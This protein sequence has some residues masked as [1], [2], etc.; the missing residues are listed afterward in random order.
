[1]TSLASPKDF[2]ILREDAGLMIA[3]DG[4]EDS[5]MGVVFRE[6]QPYPYREGAYLIPFFA[7]FSSDLKAPDDPML[8]VQLINSSRKDP[9]E[10]TLMNLVVPLLRYFSFQACALGLLPEYNA[11]NILIDWNPVDNAIR[12]VHRD[13]TGTF[14]DFKQRRI[15]GLHCNMNRYHSTDYD[16]DQEDCFRRRSFAYDFKLG[17]YVFAELEN[18]LLTDFGI[19]SERLR[20]AIKSCFRDHVDV[21]IEEYFG[22]E[23]TWYGY[24]P[25][26]PHGTRPY[27]KYSN[28]K[29]RK[30]P[31][32]NK[33]SK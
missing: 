27:V 32:R 31:L 2:A 6:F 4:S 22:S 1:M 30:E 13:M 14:K 26:L 15:L 3:Y 9:L 20:Q 25:I 28:P 24:E 23:N 21:N 17:E 8:L 12:I 11:Q 5:G 19:S 18:I 10:F 29:Y 16:E 7:L 33:G